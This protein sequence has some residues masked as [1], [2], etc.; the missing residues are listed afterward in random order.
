MLYLLWSNYICHNVLPERL[1]CLFLSF[2]SVKTVD[3]VVIRLLKKCNH[4]ISVPNIA[5]TMA[6]Q[7][8]PQPTSRFRI[9]LSFTW[10]IMAGVVL[11]VQTT[12]QEM[13]R[14]INIFDGVVL[15][16]VQIRNMFKWTIL[17]NL[18]KC[19]EGEQCIFISRTSRHRDFHLKII[20]S[21]KD[22]L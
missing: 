18:L 4:H 20:N 6:Y 9:L 7:R 12:G 13:L 14:I 21:A 19:P 2:T 15:L 1:A 11:C 8:L 22:I 5:D 17:T 10:L 16:K 3:V